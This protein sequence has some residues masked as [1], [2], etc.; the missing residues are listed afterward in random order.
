MPAV[1]AFSACK[2]PSRPVL[3]RSWLLLGR[4]AAPA[5]K[6]LTSC[7]VEQLLLATRLSAGPAELAGAAEAREDGVASLRWSARQLSAPG[8][9][10]AAS[11]AASARLAASG[12][13]GSGP[14]LP[15]SSPNCP[16]QPKTGAAAATL[17]CCVLAGLAC[18]AAGT[19]ITPGG[20]LMG[21]GPADSAGSVHVGKKGEPASLQ[22]PPLLCSWS[23]LLACRLRLLGTAVATGEQSRP[24]ASAS[25]RR[26]R[27]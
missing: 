6:L 10:A 12:V 17:G 23:L 22:V 4:T 26:S 19:R 8:R 5:K 24:A 18:A 11:A 1:R 14:S 15:G 20:R 13:E 9:A 2:A 21:A 25:W 16:S 27:R 7:R 3:C